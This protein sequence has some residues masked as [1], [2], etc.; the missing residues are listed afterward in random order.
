MSLHELPD[1]ALIRIFRRLDHLELVHLYQSCPSPARIQHVIERSPCLWTQIHLRSSVDYH[2]FVCFARLIL[3]NASNIRQLIIDELDVTCRKILFECQFTLKRFTQ[4]EQL[5]IHDEAISQTLQFINFSQWTLKTLHLTSEHANLRQLNPSLPLR[6]LQITLYSTDLLAHQFDFLTSLNVKIMFD[7]DHNAREIFNSLSHRCLQ[8]FTMKFLL[9]TQDPQF[10]VEFH[11]YL[12]SCSNLQT[13]EL[14][15]L[16][17]MCPLSL[18][19]H[20]EYEKYRRLVFINMCQ[21]K[22]MNAFVEANQCHLPDEYF[23]WNSTLNVSHSFSHIQYVFWHERQLI[24]VDYLQCITSSMEL[25][26][27]FDVLWSDKPSASQSFESYVLRSIYN[28]P[29]LTSVLRTLSVSRMDLSLNGLVML[30][31]RL[32]VLV[33]VVLSD[34]RID[35]MGAAMCDTQRMIN[36]H[37][38]AVQSGIQTMVMSNIRMSRRT[39]VNLCLITRRLV[40]LTMN[41]VKLMDKMNVVEENLN[42]DSS[43]VLVLL[44]QIA[45]CTDQFRWSTL[46]SLTLGKR[47]ERSS[48]SHI[49]AILLDQSVRRLCQSC[50]I[51]RTFFLF[52]G[53]NMINRGNLKSFTPSTIDQSYSAN[54]EHLRVITPDQTLLQ[55]HDHFCNSIRKFILI[56]SKLTSFILELTK[57]Y[58][59]QFRL[60]NQLQAMLESTIITKRVHVYP[61]AHDHA[62]RFCFDTNMNDDVDSDSASLTSSQH[63]R[64]FC[65]IPIFSLKKQR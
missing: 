13:L 57:Q 31:T 50:I 26:N 35:Q 11:R 49:H 40:S 25:L 65:G 61:T 24:S 30:L 54:I 16:H 18:H 7:H 33:D 5:I 64:S 59:G 44:K 51:D 52:S 41:E 27:Q 36:T 48:L 56:H 63:R 10:P 3:L 32:P 21:V 19:T 2:F 1:V 43:G 47:S 46:K 12:D 28:V 20:I 15:Y 17:G 8:T 4:L 9:L 42:Q 38:N 55:S 22:I 37:S 14:T 58:E 39:A 29:E 23:H 34:G 6:S 45:Q 62:C 60:R 53:K